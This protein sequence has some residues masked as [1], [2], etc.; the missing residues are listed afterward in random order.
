MSKNRIRQIEQRINRIKEKLCETGPMR[1]GTLTRQYKNPKEAVGPYWQISYTRNMRS[2]TE[3]IRQ[4]RV[5]DIRKQIAA[6]KRFK[7]LIDQWIDLSIE[8]SKLDLKIEKGN[9]S[10]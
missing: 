10:G 5:V 8:W 3:Y 6:Y 7:G 2:R 1:P 4:E 9:A